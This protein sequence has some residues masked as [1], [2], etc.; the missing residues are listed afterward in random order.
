MFPVV[1]SVQKETFELLPQAQR[2]ELLA[3]FNL[4]TRAGKPRQ[5]RDVASLWRTEVG[6][7]RMHTW[8]LELFNESSSATTCL[9]A[10]SGD[11]RVVFP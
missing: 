11:S 3:D 9:P 7:H 6:Y 1:R 4:E 5:G 2:S 8:Q 10:D